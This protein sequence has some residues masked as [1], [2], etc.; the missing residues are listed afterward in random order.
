MARGQQGNQR[1]ERKSGHLGLV[2]DAYGHDS[3]SP[4]NPSVTRPFDQP[5][6]FPSGSGGGGLPS[7]VRNDFNAVNAKV[8]QLMRSLPP[9][10]P[11]SVGEALRRMVSSPEGLAQLASMVPL[12]MNLRGRSGGPFGNAGMGDQLSELLSLQKTRALDSQPLLDTAN[13]MAFGMAPMRYRSAGP[14]DTARDDAVS[15]VLARMNRG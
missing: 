10:V 13:R 11:A 6:A 3:G 2:E 12:L 15:G 8:D 14:F 1:D 5:G 9:S 4:F 7:A